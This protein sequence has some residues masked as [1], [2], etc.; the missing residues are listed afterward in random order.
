MKTFV[1][2]VS[3]YVPAH[4]LHVD[5]GL[6]T[7]LKEPDAVILCQLS[8]TDTDLFTVGQDM[9]NNHFLLLI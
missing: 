9:G 5:A 4:L 8:T 2:L 3:G 7:G 6:C 1:L